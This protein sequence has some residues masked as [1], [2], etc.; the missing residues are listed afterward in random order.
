MIE[1]ELYFCKIFLVSVSVSNL[2]SRN[3][4]ASISVLVLV[5]E[6]YLNSSLKIT[7]I[8]EFIEFI[9]QIFFSHFANELLT[10]DE[11]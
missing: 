7:K 1:N 5:S 8:Y 4:P 6:F 9:P 10:H 2:R 11:K 3:F